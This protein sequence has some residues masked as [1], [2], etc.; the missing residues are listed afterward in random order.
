MN[1][2]Y[3]KLISQ[4]KLLHIILRWVAYNS[5]IFFYF[6]LYKKNE[7]KKFF[8]SIKGSKKGRRCFIIGNGP[9]LQSKDLDLLVNEDTF[10]VNEI[11]RLF[12]KTKWRPT[13]YFIMDRYS[14]STPEE[15]KNVECKIC[16][17]GS[18]YWLHNKVLRKDAICLY[19]H[20]NINTNSYKFSSDIS[21]YIVNAP[22]VSYAAMQVAA[23]MGYSE[24]YLLGF[25]HN[26]LFEFDK[27][28]KIIKNSISNTHFYN[29]KDPEEIIGDV[30]GMTKAYEAF[31]NYAVKNNIKVY[32]ATRGGK[33]NIFKRIDFDSLFDY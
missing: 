6:I 30:W 7:Y 2:K 21:K 27:H 8:L 25:D 17:L 3:R 15:I 32:N 33:L 12:S 10:A 28:G 22:T 5:G 9:S 14:K 31:R 18:Y 4:Y 11:H 16:F 13:Y 23:Y 1:I 26:Y 19:Q 29:D 20:Y 24:I